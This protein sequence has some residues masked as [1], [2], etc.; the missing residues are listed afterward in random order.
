[1]VWDGQARWQ[2]DS[3]QFLFNF[4]PVTPERK[5]VRLITK[6][7]KRSVESPTLTAEQW[8]VRAMELDAESPD[9]AKW[10]YLEALRLQPDL[11]DAHIQLGLLHHRESSCRTPSAAIERQWSMRPTRR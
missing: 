1:M 11:V 8:L 4:E 7:A 2:P 5:P 3:G 10:A 6:A 9:E